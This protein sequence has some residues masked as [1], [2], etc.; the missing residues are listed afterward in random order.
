MEVMEGLVLIHTGQDN[1]KW[2]EEFFYGIEE[3]GVPIF[4]LS[5][6]DVEELKAIDPY[7]MAV[8]ATQYSVFELGIG[9]DD[10]EIVVRHRLQRDALP[11][12]KCT[13]DDNAEAIRI[14]GTNTARIIKKLP[15]IL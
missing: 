6:E 7:E 3:E 9:A 5:V 11:L 4:N 14:L 1:H 2:Y 15:L 13:K 12:M 10:K 8:Y